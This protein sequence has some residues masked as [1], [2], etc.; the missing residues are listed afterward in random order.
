M[1]QI[2]RQWQKYFEYGRE[3]DKLEMREIYSSLSAS[4]WLLGAV[5]ST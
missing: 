5:G 3:A 4:L 1:S 2:D